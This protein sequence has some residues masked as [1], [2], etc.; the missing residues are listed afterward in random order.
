MVD[1]EIKLVYYEKR[2]KIQ[3]FGS[4]FVKNNKNKCKIIYEV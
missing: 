3:I 2:E 1:N 4:E